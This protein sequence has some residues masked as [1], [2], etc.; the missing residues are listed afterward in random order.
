MANMQVAESRL[1]DLK[2]VSEEATKA[3]IANS[4]LKI[5]LR[6]EDSIDVNPMQ[7]GSPDELATLFA[8]MAAVELSDAQREATVQVIKTLPEGAHVKDF[9]DACDAR[10]AQDLGVT[11]EQLEGLRPLLRALTACQ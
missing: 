2:G 1:D 11:S 5:Q 9:I 6:E 4:S 8:S 10:L 3:I 7:M